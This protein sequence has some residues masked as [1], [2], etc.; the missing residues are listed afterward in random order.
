MIYYVSTT[1]DDRA[2]GTKEA[3]FR[4]INHAAQIASAGDTVRVH[5][6]IYREWVNPKNGGTSHHNRIIY[7]AVYGELPI[8]KGSEVVTSWEKVKDTV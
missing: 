7:E 1:G 3:P 2:L 8:I 4:T 6:G 5:G